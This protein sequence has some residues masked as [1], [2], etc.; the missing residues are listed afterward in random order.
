[1]DYE[2]KHIRSKRKTI[3]IEIRQDGS[4][5]VRSP[6]R[7][8]K[9]EIALFVEKKRDWIEKNVRKMRERIE[10]Q[11]A[12]EKLSETEV[13]E[14]KMR[15]RMYIPGAVY[16]LAREMGVGYRR[17]SIRCQKTL[18]GS[19]TAKGNLS[20]NCLLMLLPEEVIRYVIIHELCHLR[21][22]NHS[23]KFWAEVEKYCPDYRRLRKQLKTEGDSLFLRV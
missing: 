20:F 10:A 6:M 8:T 15:A 5:I 21:E 14:L 1:M 11:G 19:C 22:M 18:W 23:R 3:V 16:D 7:A 12:Q 17:V 9:K 2:I 4:V 13:A